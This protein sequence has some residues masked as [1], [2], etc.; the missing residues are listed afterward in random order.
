[1]GHGP[2][3][4][5]ILSATLKV[6]GNFPYDTQLPPCSQEKQVG[7]TDLESC[8]VDVRSVLGEVGYVHVALFTCLCRS[9]HGNIIS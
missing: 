5:V 6:L 7:R 9:S 8:G 3:G 4:E 1:M 2:F